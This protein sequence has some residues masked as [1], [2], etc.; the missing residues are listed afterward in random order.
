MEKVKVGGVVIDRCHSCGS[1]WFDATELKAVLK[2]RGSIARVDRG[3]DPDG[4]R[5]DLVAHLRCPRDHQPLVTMPHKREPHIEVD[6]CPACR[7]VLLDT[8]ELTELSES[9]LR[10]SLQA[11]FD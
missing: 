7:G 8:G 9:S 10:A 2:E 5:G 11:V 1:L 3:P 4:P 6:R